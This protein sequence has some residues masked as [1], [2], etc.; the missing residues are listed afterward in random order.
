[1]KTVVQKHQDIREIQQENKKVF[2]WVGYRN[3]LAD[4]DTNVSLRVP[5]LFIATV[6]A[7][8]TKCRYHDSECT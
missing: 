3:K 6:Q 4:S 8:T 7:A 5:A 1:M 2:L